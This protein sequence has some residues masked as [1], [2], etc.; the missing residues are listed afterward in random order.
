MDRDPRLAASLSALP[1]LGQL[2]NRQPRKA[3]FFV[4]AVLL[5][6]G[7]AVLLII[8]GERVGT[9]L[10]EDQEGS[11][12]LLFAFGSILVFLALFL[13]GLTFWAGSVIDARRSAIDHNTGETSAPGRWW[14]LRL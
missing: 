9:R 13:L 2:Y 7:P 8:N 6:I 1:G 3:L 10:I 12:F 5:T 14:F 4:L 11:L